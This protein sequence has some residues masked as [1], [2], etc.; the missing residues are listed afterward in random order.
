MN[1]TI[2]LNLLIFWKSLKL[3]AGC[4]DLSSDLEDFE[5]IVNELLRELHGDVAILESL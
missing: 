5:Q 1:D 3:E 2:T 4:G